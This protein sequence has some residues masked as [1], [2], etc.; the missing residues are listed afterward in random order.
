M[1]AQ[2]RLI[3]LAGLVVSLSA[4]ASCALPEQGGRVLYGGQRDGGASASLALVCA[5]SLKAEAS[6]IARTTASPLAAGGLKLDAMDRDGVTL[7][8]SRELASTEAELSS[9]RR[10]R[11]GDPEQ[12]QRR[13]HRLEGDV[14]ALQAELRRAQGRK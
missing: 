11:G 10:L 5:P 9:V 6:K 3:A 2:G 14:A 4:N 8:L 1:V 7:I 12:V 13:I